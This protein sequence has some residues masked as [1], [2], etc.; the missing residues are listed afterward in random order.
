MFYQAQAFGRNLAYWN[1]SS[2]TNTV[3]MFRNAPRYD[4]D[5]CAWAPVL[6]ANNLSSADVQE[7]FMN[8]GCPEP[9]MVGPF[10]GEDPRWSRPGPFCRSCE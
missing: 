9:T 1:V 6:E 3:S 4:H 10:F 8:S 5:M 7:M 2:A